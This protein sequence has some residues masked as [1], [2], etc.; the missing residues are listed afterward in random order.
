MIPMYTS[1]FPDCGIADYRIQ[2]FSDSGSEQFE[3]EYVNLNEIDQTVE[4]QVKEEYKNDI[5]EYFY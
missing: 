4:F 5:E 2:S 1:P 3:N